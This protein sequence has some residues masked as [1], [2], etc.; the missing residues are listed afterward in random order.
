MHIGLAVFGTWG[1]VEPFV[2]LARALSA[3]GHRVT[4]FIESSMGA[5]VSGDS[6]IEVGEA[7]EL[8]R[9]LEDPRAMDPRFVWREVYAPRISCFHDAVVRRHGE[10]PLDVVI[11]HSWTLG[12]QLGALVSGISFVTAA[13]QPMIW[14]SREEPPR[15]DALELPPWLYR[16]LFKVAEPM[17]M[18][19]MLGRSL[20][21]E[22]R[23]LGVKIAGLGIRNLWAEASC[24]LG[25]WDPLFR[26][27]RR[28]DPPRAR[29]TGF[30]EAREFGAALDPALEAFCVSER[31]WIVAL[32]SSLPRA[33][34]RLYELARDA[35]GEPLVFVGGGAELA[36]RHDVRVVP[37]APY[38]LLFPHARG[39]IHHG[40]VGTTAHTLRAGVPQVVL[41]VGND[42]FD[43]GDRVE[44]VG[45]GRA[46]VARHVTPAELAGALDW[47]RREDVRR[48]AAQVAS[49]LTP[50]DVALAQAVDAIERSFTLTHR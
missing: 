6:V 11:A 33:Y 4:W 47:M 39:V 45:V 27:P 35:T 26:A 19:G 46:F 29:V 44:H 25:L 7:L 28:D 50:A 2:V 24:N 15:L 42:M 1:D 38:N 13:L 43:N 14:M 3:R 36:T 31:P 20:R 17:I 5:R 16:Q 18:K 21:R 22:A 41:A 49:A 37:R 40:G 10:D 8:S 32:G 48:R 23:S 12:A 30:L 9:L 34:Q